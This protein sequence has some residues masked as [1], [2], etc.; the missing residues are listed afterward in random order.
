MAKPPQWSNRDPIWVVK[1]EAI[2]VRLHARYCENVAFRATALPSTGGDSWTLCRSRETI[3][4]VCVCAAHH[5]DCGALPRVNGGGI[6]TSGPIQRDVT[7]ARRDRYL[8]LLVLLAGCTTQAP[9]IVPDSSWEA[10]AS[11]TVVVLPPDSR[12]SLVTLGGLAEEREDW[13]RTAR[14]KLQDAVASRLDRLG[15]R[16]VAYPTLAGAVP[17][18]PEDASLVTWLPRWPF[19][20]SMSDR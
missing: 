6:V 1:V 12:V 4:G 3:E 14:A 18:R 13:S 8:L 5:E 9:L 17:W 2:V 19:V 10:P 7:R 20:P 16:T 15:V 11:A